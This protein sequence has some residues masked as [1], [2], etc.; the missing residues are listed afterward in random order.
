[1][2]YFLNHLLFSDHPSTDGE[3]RSLSNKV[4]ES[5][6]EEWVIWG[7][8]KNNAVAYRQFIYHTN[9]LLLFV[10]FILYSEHQSLRYSIGYSLLSN[11]Q[12]LYSSLIQKILKMWDCTC[13]PHFINRQRHNKVGQKNNNLLVFAIYKIIVV[14]LLMI[15]SLSTCLQ[16]QFSLEN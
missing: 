12:F 15:F 7:G 4:W 3:M 10:L 16:K 5:W 9:W 13:R 14:N 6:C 11:A 2:R 1:M 8:T